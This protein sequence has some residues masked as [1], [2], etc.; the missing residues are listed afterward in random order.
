MP[1]M[2]RED[3][4]VADQINIADT[5][6]AHDADQRTVRLVA[7]EA[8]PGGD[9][10]FKLVQGHI[11]VVPAIIGNDAAISLGGSVDDPKNRSAIIIT[12]GPNAAH[13]RTPVSLHCTDPNLSECRFLDSHWLLLIGPD[14][15]CIMPLMS[16]TI[17]GSQERLQGYVAATE[18]GGDFT[19][20]IGLCPL[21]Q[22]GHSNTGGAFDHPTLHLRDLAHRESDL[23]LGDRDGFV[24]YGT[25]I[26]RTV[27]GFLGFDGETAP[28]AAFRDDWHERINRFV[29]AWTAKQST[30]LDRLD[31]SGR[32]AL[33]EAL[34][35]SGGFEGRRSP[36]Y[37]AQ[38]LG[39][40]RA[41]VYNELARLKARLAA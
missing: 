27:Q 14:M 7:P 33:I 8:D 23:W 40:S 17:H 2:C 10:P 16:T 12:T 15:R 1:L 36:A 28:D 5:L 21:D 22:P 25:A 38:I 41:T 37:V 30:T 13:D 3:V 24:D 4:G 18:H 20:F 31:R 34:H 29:A 26:Q 35:T 11:R 9:L 39:V 6:D 19:P 32:R